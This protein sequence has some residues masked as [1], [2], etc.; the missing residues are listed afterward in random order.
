MSS[1][2]MARAAGEFVTG[3]EFAHRLK[4]LKDSLVGRRILDVHPEQ[5]HDDEIVA[6]LVLDNGE[7]ISGPVLGEF[8]EGSGFD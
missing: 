1:L 8:S 7:T 4:K 5:Y 3:K 2:C 6:M